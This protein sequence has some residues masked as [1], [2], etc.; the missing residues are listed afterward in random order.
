[1]TKTIISSIEKV[2]STSSQTKMSTEM[3]SGSPDYTDIEKALSAKINALKNIHLKMVHLE[4]KFYDELH[5][6]ESKYA[7]LYEPLFDQREKIITGEHEPSDQEGVWTLDEQNIENN[8][9]QGINDSGNGND[10]KDLIK[11]MQSKIDIS[12]SLN[13]TGVPHFWLQVFKRTDLIMD[14]IQSHDED[15]LL[16]LQNIKCIMKP[17]KPYGYTLQFHF[18]E[19]DYFTNKVLTK[20]YELT[21]DHDSMNPLLYDGPVM[22]KSEGCVINWNKGKDVTIRTIKK[23]QKHKS[24]GTVRV[25]LKEEKQD[26]FFNY[27]E[28]PT[29]DGIRPSYRSILNPNREINA[30]DDDEDDDEIGE[31]LCN[32]DFEIGHFFKEYIVPKAVLYYTGDLIDQASM[33]EDEELED[34]FEENNENMNGENGTEDD[35]DDDDDK[36]NDTEGMESGEEV[37]QSKNQ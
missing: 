7:M 18:A 5:Q 32:A 29:S 23:R 6:L 36:E 26:S 17:L 11:D 33:I 25:V 12:D 37:T 20:S 1:M 31:E 8:S 22:Y 3:S 13:L 10:V 14:M 15:V 35:D 28:K 24:T 19:N 2:T 21:C 4:E 34:Y 9:K 27:F 16:H 30:E